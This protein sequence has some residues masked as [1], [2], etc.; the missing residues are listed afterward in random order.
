MI[1]RFASRLF[2]YRLREFRCR[3]NNEYVSGDATVCGRPKCTHIHTYAHTTLGRE[4][5]KA[6]EGGTQGEKQHVKSQGNIELP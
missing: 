3:Q 5:Y 1:A 4:A 2:E 6:R